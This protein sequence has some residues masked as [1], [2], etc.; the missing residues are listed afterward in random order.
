[1]KDLGVAY[2]LTLV[3]PYSIDEIRNAMLQNI[4]AASKELTYS[5]KSSS[6]PNSWHEYAE[7]IWNA[8]LLQT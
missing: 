6:Y 5:D 2:D 8:L 7:R 4:T 1:M 3:D